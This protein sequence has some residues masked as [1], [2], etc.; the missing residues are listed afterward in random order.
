MSLMTTIETLFHEKFLLYRDLEE[1]LQQERRIILNRE[2][3]TDA[4]WEFSGKKH[5]TVRKIEK[6]RGKILSALTE[7]SIDHQMTPATFSVYTVLSLVPGGDSRRIKSH[8]VSLMALKREVMAMAGE[9]KRFVDE[10]LD[11]VNSLMAVITG[12]AVDPAGHAN[13]YGNAYTNGAGTADGANMFLHR[14]V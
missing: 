14:E 11:M 5:D 12:S 4:L 13:G 7:A 3:D 2:L 1:W 10:Q 6:I 8:Q 9:N